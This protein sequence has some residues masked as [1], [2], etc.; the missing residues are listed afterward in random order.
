MRTRHRGSAARRM[1]KFMAKRRHFSRTQR[2]LGDDSSGSAH[3][4]IPDESF[5]LAATEEEVL[6]DPP[7]NSVRSEK[8][9]RARELVQDRDY[10]SPDVLHSVAGLL[11]QHLSDVR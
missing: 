10:P 6:S 11:A 9:R 7:W 2:G 4:L 1:G 3:T 5:A 8:V